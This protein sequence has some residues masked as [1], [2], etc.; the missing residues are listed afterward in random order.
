MTSDVCIPDLTHWL[1]EEEIFERFVLFA[2]RMGLTL[3]VETKDG[4]CY[5]SKKCI[6]CE[7]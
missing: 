6:K 2:K 4:R 7:S 3:E 1:S 5:R